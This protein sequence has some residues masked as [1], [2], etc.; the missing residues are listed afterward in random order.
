MADLLT[1]HSGLVYA[2]DLGG[3]KIMA[4]LCD[5]TG[6]FLARERV[7]TDS[8][9]GL[10]VVGQIAAL[11]D[12]LAMRAGLDRGLVGQ[13]AI[14]VPGAPERGSGRVLMAPNIPGFDAMDV[15][16]AFHEALG[17]DTILENDVN[18]GAVG[19]NA[20]GAG[21]GCLDMAFIAPGTGIGCGLIADGRLL[22]GHANAAGEIAFL[23]FGADPFEAGSLAT[24]AFERAAGSFGM[25]KRYEAL[26]GR[27]AGVPAIFE[28][29]AQGDAAAVTTL[30]ETARLLARGIV[31]V[32]ALLNPEKIVLGGSIGLRPEM[33]ERLRGLLPL[34]FPHPIHVE[35]GTLG[36]DAALSGAA[37]TAIRQRTAVISTST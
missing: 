9:G 34:C 3:T 35:P 31:A 19:E 5:M 14:G 17:C 6:R 8:R 11:C 23:P 20:M 27:S 24:G 10:H 33:L 29:A 21:R 32:A 1:T 2:V 25:M 16:S 15:V 26:S 13:A 18:L 7:P 37:V 36:N 22:R 12:A 30:D 28:Q 4:A